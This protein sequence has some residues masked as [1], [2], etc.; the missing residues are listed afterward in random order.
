MPKLT[1]KLI[2]AA[3]PRE[4][5]YFLWDSG[6]GA[7]KGF[8]LRVFASGR[9]SFLLQYR[10]KGRKNTRRYTIG[11]YGDWTVDEARDEAQEKRRAVR[12]GEDPSQAR[13]EAAHGPTVSDL[14]DRYLKE[15]AIPRKKPRS[16]EGDRW[17]LEKHIKPHFGEWKVED[18]IHADVDNF[19]ASMH[20]TPILA[21]RALALLSKMFERAEFWKL[22]K[23]GTS[24]TR[25]IERYDEKKHRRKRYLSAAE[26]THLGESLREI[27]QERP[28]WASSIAA[29]RVAV[30]T[31]C[32][33]GE[34][35]N[36][37]WSEVDLDG[38]KLNLT[39]SKTGPKDVFLNAPALQVIAG[40]ERRSEW[41]FPRPDGS[42]PLDLT[43][44]WRRIRSRA[45]LDDVR[46]HDLRHSHAS[47]GVSAGLG[48]PVLAK[49]LGH[50]TTRTTELYGH[51]ADDPIRAASALIG[52]RI[53]ASLEG[54]EE[55][56]VVP[57]ET[58]D[59]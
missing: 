14:A 40:M 49:L 54:R 16:V 34:L 19:H 18:V 4:K 27:E 55:A 6:D 17:L 39:D 21:N 5:D 33:R 36:L 41:V 45:G 31:G 1:K 59:G 26:L 25:G 50:A 58:R 43:P 47:V 35:E 48:F 9:K 57:L 7:V 23:R 32:R 28:G 51:L 30:L 24:P 15:Y 3:K 2:D 38:G 42:G 10:V 37:R 52:N 44:A 13:H 46:V 20:G 22:R 12:K 56:E 8:G 53:A 11:S 29:L